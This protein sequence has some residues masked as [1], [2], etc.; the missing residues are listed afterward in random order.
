MCYGTSWVFN[1]VLPAPRAVRLYFVLSFDRRRG[2]QD[3]IHTCPWVGQ[4]PFVNVW[5]RRPVPVP[6][7]ENRK[8]NHGGYAL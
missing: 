5:Q 4:Y 2:P 1:A 6:G 3:W 8:D 7:R